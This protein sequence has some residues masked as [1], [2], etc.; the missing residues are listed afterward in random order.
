MRFYLSDSVYS[1]KAKLI[2]FEANNKDL[3]LL[4]TKVIVP[5]Y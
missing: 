1:F 2:Y 3:Y 5:L 4:Y